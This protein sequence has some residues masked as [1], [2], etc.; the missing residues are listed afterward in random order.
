MSKHAAATKKDK[1]SPRST[2]PFRLDGLRPAPAQVWGRVRLIPLIADGAFDDSLRLGL[3]RYDDALWTQAH[4]DDDL[5]YGSTFVPHAMIVDWTDDGAPVASWS[6]QLIAASE[7]RAAKQHKIGSRCVVREL[8][9]MIQR[10]QRGRLRFLPMHL[11]LEGLMSEHFGGPDTAWSEWSRD[12]LRHGLSPRVEQMLMGR[13]VPDLDDALRLFEL[14]QGQRGVVVLVGDTLASALVVPTPMDYRAMHQALI[15]DFYAEI[16]LYYNLIDPVVQQGISLGDEPV[17]SLEELR[18]R[19]DV[20]SA[21]YAAIELSLA[22]ELTEASLER[23][24]RYKLGDRYR[25]ESFMTEPDAPNAEVR[26]HAGEVIFDSRGR[27]QYL[28]TMRLSREQVRRASLLKL[29]SRAGWRLEEA[30][31]LF[32]FPLDQFIRHLDRAGLGHLLAPRLRRRER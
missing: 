25:L 31:V 17:R 11:A 22:G 1:T 3:R 28:K 10:E 8:N 18:A 32:G 30:A 6:T 26:S 13:Y 29:L 27:I 14:H 16:F 2:T 23:R 4:T 12:A 15:Q 19:L 21:S 20:A 5:Y 24:V 7:E 9:R